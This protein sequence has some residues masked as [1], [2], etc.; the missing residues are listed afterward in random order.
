M[1]K[2]LDD[3]IASGSSKVG[4]GVSSP[5]N[6]LHISGNLDMRGNT[7][8]EF[9]TTQI[10]L[11]AYNG[12]SANTSDNLGPGITWKPFYNT[13][14]KR[15]AGILQ[16][17]EG[18]YF[19]S[20]LAFFTNN[21][22]NSSTDWSERMRISMDGNVG[23]GTTSP[24]VKL[25]VSGDHIR[26][27]DAYSLQW[28]SANNRIYNQS[29]ATVFVNNASESM[30]IT[31]AGNVGIGTSSPSYPFS[32]ENSGTGLISRIYNTNTDGQGLLI[33]A[34]ATSSA[35][36]AFQVAS[37]NDTKIMTVNSNGRV[38]IGTNSPTSPLTI[39]SNSTSSADSGL[40]IQSTGNTNA[41]LKIAE[42]ST[43][44]GRFH[45]YDGGVEKIAFYTDGT[46]NHIS[47]G[48]FGIGTASPST[49]LH[50]TGDGVDFIATVENTGT[51][52]GKSG[53]W[54]KTDSTW[55]NALILKLTGGTSDTSIM[56]VNAA[57]VRIGGGT[58]TQN[59]Q[60]LHLPDSKKIGLGDSSDLQ[61]Y[62]DGSFSRI[63]ADG[64]GDLIISQKTADKDIIFV[65]DDGSGGET[66][67]FKLDGSATTTVFSKDTRHIDN[68]KALFGGN[69]DFKIYHDGTDS[70]VQNETGDLEFQNRQND[71]DIKF[72][73]D[74]GSG[75]VTEYFRLDGSVADGTNLVTRFPD[76]SILVFGS[77]SGFQD[78]MQIYHNGTNSFVS[79]YVGDLE[80]RQETND[81]DIVFKS[82]DGS[83]GTT[84]YITLDGS[85]TKTIM[86]KT[87]HF[88]D[89]VK[90]QMGNYASP[91]LQIYHDGSNSFVADTG[92]GG[93]FLEGNS[94]V[95]IRKQGTS[96]IMLQC[97]A[98]GA[99]NLYHN[100]VKKFETKSDGVDITGSLA[101]SS[102]TTYDGIQ[103]SGAS[104]PTL[105]ITDTTNNA[106][107]VA[108][109]RDSDAH[110]GQNQTTP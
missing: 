2:F 76:Q 46:A 6:A 8:T 55:T 81:G 48:N 68:A 89:N 82:D 99:V 7:D 95:R 53:L 87:V 67:Y 49:V 23:I 56:E 71:G 41:I 79:N 85:H 28:A 78:G 65:S 24:G 73:S 33:R 57:T 104:I 69:N 106:K 91:D 27:S 37:S 77:G 12:N 86:G 11:N 96:E 50:A 97:V 74:D 21:T 80:I 36:R 43:D 51:G 63:D 98:D 22:S 100:N 108:Y 60:A 94:E 110:I 5:N 84:A 109:A 9:D 66:T 101:V 61:I 15:S 38:G 62:H 107:L 88:D 52:T 20:G 47:A 59:D 29:S 10:F 4:I 16:I 30:R 90:I 19:K 103:I 34:G 35:T 58:I 14:S 25:E 32:L 1:P 18:N 54:V 75:G 13:Y 72:K 17:A 83:G 105:S 40:T 70:V 102:D 3:I 92:T 45:M 93:L 31:S 42:K 26:L 39:K 64:T 44:G